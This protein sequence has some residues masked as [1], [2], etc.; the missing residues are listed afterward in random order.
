EVRRPVVLRQPPEPAG[1]SA[2]VVPFG[3]IRFVDDIA[4]GKTP[5]RTRQIIQDLSGDS[6][7]IGVQSREAGAGN[8]R[9]C[10]AIAE[11]C[12]GKLFDSRVPTVRPVKYALTACLERM[13]AADPA[14]GVA[15]LPRRIVV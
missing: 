2:E 14:Q 15:N 4:L 12:L 8:R 9:R 7:V 5:D 6:A 3:L 1:F 10:R 11:H 13:L